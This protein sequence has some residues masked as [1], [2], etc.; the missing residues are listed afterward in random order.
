MSHHH[1]LNALITASADSSMALR[2]SSYEPGFRGVARNG[3][4]F[5]ITAARN[6]SGKEVLSATF[7]DGNEAPLAETDILPF[8][9]DMSAER[10]PMGKLGTLV[11]LAFNPDFDLYVKTSLE[12]HNLPVDPKM[13]WAKWLEDTFRQMVSPAKPEQRDEAIHHM[14]VDNLY[15]YDAVAKFDAS[16]LPARVQELPLEEQVSSYLKGYFLLQRSDCVEWVKKTYG[17]VTKELL[18]LDDDTSETD[19]L[20]NPEYSEEDNDFAGAV[21]AMDK[22]K[23]RKAFSEFATRQLSPSNREKIMLCVNLILDTKAAKPGEIITR[24]AEQGSMEKASATK[25]FFQTLPLHI[26]RFMK[27]TEG[28]ALTKKS[29]LEERPMRPSRF[30]AKK[31]AEEPMKCSKCGQNMVN[32]QCPPCNGKEK[33]EN[34]ALAKS[35]KPEAPKTGPQVKSYGS[36]TEANKISAVEP[37]QIAQEILTLLTSGDKATAISKLDANAAASPAFATVKMRVENNDIDG[38]KKQLQS[39][40]KVSSRKMAESEGTPSAWSIDNE[41]V[42]PHKIDEAEQK[43]KVSSKVAK[44]AALKR[45]AEEAPKDISAALMELSQAMSTLAEASEA[46]VENLDL[47]PVPEDGT[48][49]EKVASR[50]K[51]AATLRR[52]A[53]EQPE[54]V[55]SAVKELYSSLDEIASAMENLAGNLGID[56]E[57][58]TE[59]FEN[60][61]M[62]EGIDAPEILDEFEDMDDNK[63]AT[64]RQRLAARKAARKVKG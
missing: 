56:L 3:K 20:N 60:A 9:E 24:L 63:E 48:I 1:L 2:T 22:E 10:S 40:A 18:L 59:T 16:R 55:E 27:T 57:E 28:K 6:L 43:I 5:V 49:K 7:E 31:I 44:Y 46:L 21:D 26:D 62:E 17:D 23:F 19:F 15:R 34:D 35:N 45:A 13:N 58:P 53:S 14:L 51:F 37:T 4:S 39:I 8:T 32:G 29:N 25:L 36:D 52:M 64:L 61:P 30:A 42:L 50:K 12:N 38:A 54:V 33:R 41:R 11:R 47:T